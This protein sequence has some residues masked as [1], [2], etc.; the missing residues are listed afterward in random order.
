MILLHWPLALLG[1]PAVAAV[2]A[3]ALY[4]PDRQVTIVGSLSLWRQAIQSLGRS[5]HRARR[6]ST[7]WV[8]LLAGAL[9]AVL[10]GAGPVWLSH[11]PARQVTIAVYPS[12]ELDASRLR[13]AAEDLLDR[14][15]ESDRVELLLPE[16][17]GGGTFR[18]LSPAEAR[19]RLSHLPRLPARAAELRLPEP[20]PV[21]R[22]V[23]RLSVA[24]ADF[25]P[26]PNVTNIEMPA[27]FPRE[28]IETVAAEALPGGKAQVLAAVRMPDGG[29]AQVTV[30]SLSADGTPLATVSPAL[31]GTD[32]GRRAIF[33]ATVDA[34]DAFCI[35]LGTGDG[36]G[37]SAYLARKTV[38]SCSVAFV[39]RD[40]PLLRR[41]VRINPALRLATDAKGADLVIANGADAP[42]GVA[43]LVFDPPSQPA[44]W[45]RGETLG[46]L[47]LG[48][49]D[50]AADDP[51]LRYVDLRH[52]AVRRATPW[53]S[54]GATGLRR[55]VSWR[56]DALVLAD[57]GGLGRPRRVYVAF[58]PAEEN[59]TFARSEAF[60]IFLSNVVEFLAGA[61]PGEIRY[62]CAAPL[63][64][65]TSPGWR[66]VVGGEGPPGPLPWPGL[67]RDGDGVL[68]AVSLPPL[69]ADTPVVAP[70]QAIAAAPLPEP[71]PIGATAALWPALLAAAGLL[72][73]A[74]WAARLR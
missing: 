22:H 57:G 73:I 55:V 44:P 49:A 13:A 46:P 2:A 60:V 28:R 38:S 20:S 6:V 68:H 23:Y 69:H 37:R 14:L 72:W 40:D 12:A 3:W 64:T 9:L 63:A 31:A 26:G 50:R 61:R 11:R 17:L 30:E 47:S 53:V 25:A 15:D 62:E 16:L 33:V 70:A 58:D 52:V 10:A 7:A 1:L 21:S 56:S 34:P 19:Q 29:A 35:R 65:P 71:E 36:I 18:W 4:R 45:R 67:H 32:A 24:G 39:G 43:A 54:A 8:L 51:L 27:L 48:D 5:A 41:Y 42:A 59:T 66:T 74:G